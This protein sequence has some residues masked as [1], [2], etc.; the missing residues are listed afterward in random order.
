MP[1]LSTI[2]AVA[3]VL[4]FMIL[5]H[6]F[7]H[8][9]EINRQGM[10]ATAPVFIPFFGAG[11]FQREHPQSSKVAK[12]KTRTCIAMSLSSSPGLSWIGFTILFWRRSWVTP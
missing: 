3:V 7:G 11:I 6:E 4:G 9:I 2:V 5:I 1:S 12:K 8:V 10:K